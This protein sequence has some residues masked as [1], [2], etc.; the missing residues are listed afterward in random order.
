MSLKVDFVFQNFLFITVYLLL[1]AEVRPYDVGA[2]MGISI[3]FI[4][5]TLTNIMQGDF[6]SEN[7]QIRVQFVLY[8]CRFCELNAQ[9]VPLRSLSGKYRINCKRWDFQKTLKLLKSYCLKMCLVFFNGKLNDF[10]KNKQVYNCSKS[11]IL[12][13]N[14]INLVHSSLEFYSLW[15]TR[16]MALCRY[17]WFLIIQ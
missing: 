6:S 12:K 16:H 17:R 11:R 8:E 15:V 5:S 1:V 10:A 2:L 4:A 9:G 13:K 7:Q 3:S 14:W